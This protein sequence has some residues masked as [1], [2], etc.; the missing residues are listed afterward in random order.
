MNDIL[1][2]LGVAAVTIPIAIA[3]SWFLLVYGQPKKATPLGSGWWMID[4]HGQRSRRMYCSLS[5]EIADED[6]TYWPRG[7]FGPG[8]AKLP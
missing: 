8:T 5:C 4:F 1:E 6:G 2:V 3:I 7:L